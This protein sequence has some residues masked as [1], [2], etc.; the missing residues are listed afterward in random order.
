MYSF[1]RLKNAIDVYFNSE[2]VGTAYGA[3]TS[4]QALRIILEA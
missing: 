2:Y 4:S 3:K 1:V